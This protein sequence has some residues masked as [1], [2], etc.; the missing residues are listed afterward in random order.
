MR[1]FE[2]K[3]LIQM[4]DRKGWYGYGPDFMGW[5][6]EEAKD[7]LVMS[8]HGYQEDECKEEAVWEAL[9]FI[10]DEDNRLRC[11]D[12]ITSG[13]TMQMANQ[14]L[15]GFELAQFKEG[16]Y[17]YYEDDCMDMVYD[18]LCEEDIIDDNKEPHGNLERLDNIG[19]TSL[20]L[21][22]F[23]GRYV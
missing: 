23:N 20:Y 6:D 9:S 2:R 5:K 4:L 8:L 12:H 3:R 21:A 13:C 16:L 14:I 7:S 19:R 18:A 1:H 17:A 10:D 15:T 11:C 22:T